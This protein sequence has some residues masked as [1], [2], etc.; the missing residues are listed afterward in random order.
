MA[1]Q[2]LPRATT[3]DEKVAQLRRLQ[4]R[5]DRA[6]GA[7]AQGDTDAVDDVAAILRTLVGR[8]KGNDLIR[9]TRAVM[10]LKWPL[11][12][13]GPEAKDTGVRLSAGSI[14]ARLK[15]PEGDCRWVRL[16]EWTQA[17]AVVIDE[18]HGQRKA[19]WEKLI[20]DYANTFGSHAS[21]S[22]PRMLDAT[23]RM[24][25]VELNLGQYMIHC[26]GLGIADAVAQ[27]LDEFEG[28][29]VVKGQLLQDRLTPLY[30]LIIGAGP[31]PESEVRIDDRGIS[32]RTHVIKMHL[33]P[34]QWQRVFVE[35]D[36]ENDRTIVAFD[37]HDAGTP[38]WW[39]E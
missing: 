19:T 29:A 32:E 37:I 17:L 35:P 10:N 7:I 9:R 25:A 6:L 23:A 1:E 3:G 20:E 28:K 22:I 8:G 4:R 16:D 12:F 14:P 13:V 26:A 34:H 30:G 38:D 11:L 5:L 15:M 2:D 21:Q 39:P 27:M 18:G 36:P 24:H 33:Y 31:A